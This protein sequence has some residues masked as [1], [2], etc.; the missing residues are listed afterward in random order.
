M[1]LLLDNNSS[2]QVDLCAVMVGKKGR[3]FRFLKNN[4]ITALD[5]ITFRYISAGGRFGQSG[6]ISVP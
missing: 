2:L 6:H 1:Q 4:P 3:H 5:N